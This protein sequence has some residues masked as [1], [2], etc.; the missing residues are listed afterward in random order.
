M[1]S[2]TC[3]V[4]TRLPEDCR[5]PPPVDRRPPRA[6]PRPPR[7]AQAGAAQ[8]VSGDALGGEGL[9]ADADLVGPG[10]GVHDEVALNALHRRLGEL[11]ELFVQPQPLDGVIACGQLLL[12]LRDG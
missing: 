5:R 11:G 3:S 8:H 4:V 12:G 9:V 2:T 7:G 10:L 6:P 1:C